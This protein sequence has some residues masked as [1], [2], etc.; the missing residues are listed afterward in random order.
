MRSAIVNYPFSPVDPKGQGG[1]PP[2]E[3]RRSRLGRHLTPQG[4]P[5]SQ[6]HASL[7]VRCSWQLSKQTPELMRL[8]EK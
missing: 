5:I 3:R 7:A 4:R 6:G 1:P 2:A 8:D